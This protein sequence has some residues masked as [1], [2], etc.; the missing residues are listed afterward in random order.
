MMIRSITSTLIH[1]RRYLDLTS[2]SLQSLSM[3]D[4][5][6]LLAWLQPVVIIWNGVQKPSAVKTGIVPHTIS[7]QLG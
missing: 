1:E 4:Q 5:R 7:S 3:N 2:G 6:Y